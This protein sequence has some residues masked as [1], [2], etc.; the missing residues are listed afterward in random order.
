MRDYGKV[1]TQF[2]TSETV[3]DLSE[4]GRTLALYLLTCPHGTIAG[5]FRLPDGYACEDLQWSSERVQQGFVELFAK[6]FAKRCAKTKWVWVVKHLEWNPPE[7]PN[8]RKAA[9]K[10]V[11]Q[12]PEQ[13]AWLADFQRVCVEHLGS[14]AKREKSS[15]GTLS[16]PFLNQEQEQ[17]ERANALLS[18]AEAD[19][20]VRHD[21]ESTSLPSCPHREILALFAERL[22]ELPQPRLELWTGTRAQALA[23]RWKWVMTAKKAGGAR[24]ATT[25]A[26][27]IDF[28]DR[29]FAYVAECPHLVGKNGRQWTADLAWL[30]KAENF[31]KVLQGNY[32]IREAA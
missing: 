32:E 24:Y 22:P 8:Q 9:S 18:S 28:F 30:C 11:T 6:G 14:S 5:V 12:V 3:R 20:E 29:L 7:N 10:V 26:E 15:S 4:D 2:W 16:E 27:A 25:K 21:E 23:A 13:C 19:D 1:H 31:A 17:E